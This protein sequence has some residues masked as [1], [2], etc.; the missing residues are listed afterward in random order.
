MSLPTERILGYDFCTLPAAG[1]APHVAAWLEAQDGKARHIACVNPHSIV[2]ALDDAAF[3]H[4]LHRADMTV[5]DGVGI[6]L[7]SKF[8]GGTIAERVTGFDVFQLTCRL[9]NDRAG[10]VMFLGSSEDVLAI[11]AEKMARDFPAIT[12][13]TY[14][15][16]YKSA[17][18]DEDNAAMHRAVNTFRP[19]VLWVGMTAPK[20]EKWVEGNRAK[21]DTRMIG[22]IGAVFD[23][24]AGRIKRPARV[25]RDLGLEWLPRLVGE[26][27]RLWRRMGIS[28]PIFVAEVVKDRFRRK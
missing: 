17:F 20:Q 5:P 13:E 19:D 6:V 12:V 2:V 15:P 22:S 21:L 24:Y 28:A 8:Q 4:A 16:P 10:K 27:R 7:A 26:P 3:R 23:F 14:S 18:S 11:I 25:W 9:V 1:L